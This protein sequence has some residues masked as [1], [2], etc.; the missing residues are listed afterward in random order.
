MNT[1]KNE[2]DIFECLHIPYK[3]PHQREHNWESNYQIIDIVN[4]AS[5]TGTADVSDDD[6][7]GDDDD[8]DDGEGDRETFALLEREEQQ[9]RPKMREEEMWRLLGTTD[10][11]LSVSSGSSGAGAGAGAGAGTSSTGADSLDKG[12]TE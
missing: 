4:S 3:A 9:K 11:L 12:A 10:K 1:G 8:D 5:A 2:R 6:D 7:D